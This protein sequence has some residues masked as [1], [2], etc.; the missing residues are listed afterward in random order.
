MSMTVSSVHVTSP[1]STK[2]TNLDFQVSHSTNP[3]ENSGLI[4]ICTEKFQFVGLVDLLEENMYDSFHCKRYISEM[5]Q[6]DKLRFLYVS[7][8]SDVYIGQQVRD[9]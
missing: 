3:N 1:K 9:S 6:I 2:S 4:G 7:R 5:Q 8:N